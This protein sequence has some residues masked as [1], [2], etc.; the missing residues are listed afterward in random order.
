MQLSLKL[1]TLHDGRFPQVGIIIAPSINDSRHI[2][3]GVDNNN[4]HHQ[5]F[6]CYRS[7]G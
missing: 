1:K 2:C 3:S 5:Q 7:V 6:A 4:G